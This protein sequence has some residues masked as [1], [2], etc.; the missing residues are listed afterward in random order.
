MT[1]MVGLALAVPFCFWPVTSYPCDTGPGRHG[2]Y[3]LAQAALPMIYNRGYLLKSSLSIMSFSFA[4]YL[5]CSR[6]LSR[7]R[8]TVHVE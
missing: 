7:G 5:F 1:R 3:S 8:D 2:G 4:R 6:E